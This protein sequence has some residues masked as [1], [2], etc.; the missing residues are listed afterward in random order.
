MRYRCRIGPFIILPGQILLFKANNVAHISTIPLIVLIW[1]HEQKKIPPSSDPSLTNQTPL[2]CF[3]SNSNRKPIANM[4]FRLPESVL[5]TQVWSD[6]VQTIR[7]DD[8]YGNGFIFIYDVLTLL[9]LPSPF[10]LVVV[11]AVLRGGV[12]SQREQKNRS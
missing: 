5:F 9:F 4:P 8:K 1:F 12:C 3:R 11:L 6:P 7:P 10:S 2:C